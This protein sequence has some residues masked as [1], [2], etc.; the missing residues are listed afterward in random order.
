MMLGYATRMAQDNFSTNEGGENGLTVDGGIK[1][2]SLI[3]QLADEHGVPARVAEAALENLLQQRELGQADLD[4]G[5]L[6]L[7][8]RQKAGRQV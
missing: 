6:V 1:D 8:I 3:K 7:A 2:A 4:F 5:S